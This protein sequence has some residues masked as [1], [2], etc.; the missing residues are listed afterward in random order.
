MRYV[1]SR[2]LLLPLMLALTACQSAAS[3]PAPTNP[4]RVAEV[5]TR[6]VP[7]PTAAA[8]AVATTVLPTAVAIAAPTAVATLAVKVTKPTAKPT[9]IPPTTAPSVTK[10]TVPP[11]AKP[12]AIPPVAI[13]GTT[14]LQLKAGQGK[15]Q[16][17]ITADDGPSTFRVAADG[18]YR[19]MDP[20]NKR[21]LF[22]DGTSGKLLQTLNLAF[23]G[24]PTD[25]VVSGKGDLYVLDAEGWTLD[26]LE[27]SGKELRNI[28]LNPDLKGQFT[29]ITLTA[30]GRIY[31]LGAENVYLL[32]TADGALEPETQGIS[33]TGMYTVRSNAVF[34]LLT[35]E[36]AATPGE[37][38][39]YISTGDPET[40]FNLGK[41]SGQVSFVDVNQ[42][43]QPYI[44]ISA[45]GLTE[46]RRFDVQGNLLGTL[47]V[48]QRGC[49]AAARSLY[50]DRPGAVYSMCVSDGGVTIQRYVMADAAGTPLPLFSALVTTAPW[51]PGN[52]QASPG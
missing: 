3:S 21:L 44:A 1:R 11:T 2:K 39:L 10:P 6:P 52:L 47:T 17:G 49:R 24:R 22:F 27:V 4:P 28:P 38:D 43:M 16:V 36:N 14:V 32:V 41:L 20:V 7:P 26:H 31:G 35:G 34:S 30:D 37:T 29:T 19:I 15:G 18:S 12:T 33:G 50:I 42:G 9:A 40:R 8:T 45:G 46:I 5:V 25:F 51:S 48:D 13:V 23:L